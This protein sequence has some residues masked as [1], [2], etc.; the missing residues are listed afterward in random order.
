MRAVAAVI[1]LVALLAAPF[2]AAQTPL[3]NPHGD[4]GT[5]VLVVT[6]DPPTRGACS[7]CHPSHGKEPAE[8]FKGELFTENSN[9]LCF[10]T[11]GDGAC[12]QAQPVNYPLREIDRIPVQTS[13][14]DP[15]YFE[16]NSAGKRT[17]G[18]DRRGRWPGAHVYTDAGIT[19]AGRYYSPHAHDSNMPRRDA[20]GEGLCL[21]CHDVHGSSNPFDILVDSYRGIGGHDQSG[22]PPQYRLCLRC[23]GRDGPAGMDLD[24]K[25]IEDYYDRGLNPNAGHQIKL[26][27]RIAL[28]WPPH[29]RRG[30]MLPCYDC[31]NPHGS[32]GNN[33]AAPNAFLLS[34]QR[35]GWSGLTDP[36]NDATQSRRFCLGCHIPADGVPG[37]Q[38][39]EGISMNTLSNLDAHLGSSPQSCHDCHGRDYSGPKANNVHNPSR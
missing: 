6:T 39:V 27:A 19:V 20:S 15:G 32:Q 5:G 4:P 2:S 23:H 31:H 13:I 22:P 18:V 29:L 17:A 16:A 8:T 9:Q 3:F 26:N 10:S 7:Q 33:R 21:N 1:L 34:D 11:S 12:H 25:F 28:S 24:N 38:T 14:Q 35:P 36:S 30:D 37:T